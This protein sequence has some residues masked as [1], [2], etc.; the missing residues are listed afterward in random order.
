MGLV[1]HK[2]KDMLL[3]TDEASEE[4][5]NNSKKSVS[6]LDDLEDLDL[7]DVVIPGK[8]NL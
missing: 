1:A 8:K 7:R 4:S 3:V 2:G 6:H 5:E